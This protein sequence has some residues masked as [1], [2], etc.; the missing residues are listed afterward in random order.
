MEDSRFIDDPMKC[1]QAL[2]NIAYL[3][4]THDGEELHFQKVWYCIANDELCA[5]KAEDLSILTYLEG[6][7]LLDLVRIASFVIELK[8]NLSLS[9]PML[10]LMSEESFWIAALLVEGKEN[11]RAELDLLEPN[12]ENKNKRPACR[13]KIELFADEIAGGDVGDAEEV[14]EAAGVGAF[15]DT[16]AAEEDPLD[17]RRWKRRSDN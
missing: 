6:K 3:C 16:E 11:T 5:A 13:T 14:A 12:I 1:L 7:H 10:N 8:D 9:D 4:I 15:S 2:P 17:V